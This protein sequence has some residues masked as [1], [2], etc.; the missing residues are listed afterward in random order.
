MPRTTRIALLALVALIAGAAVYVTTGRS[1]TSKPSAASVTSGSVSTTADPPSST[2]STT[3]AP[4]PVWRIVWGSTMA[5]GYGEIDNATVRQLATVKTAGSEIR[6]RVSNYF[7][8]APLQIGAATVAPSAGGSAIDA[9]AVHQVT[10]NGSPTTVIPVGGLA[11][12]DPIPMPVTG[13]ETLAISLWVS[14]ADL[15]TLHPC[16][17]TTPEGW[18]TANGRGNTTAA[19]NMVGFGTPSPWRRFVDAVDALQTTGRGSIVVIGDSITDGF[20]SSA[21]WTD[22]L[23]ERV[24][25]LPPD[26][27][28]AIINEA[29]TA[30]ALTAPPGVHTD[31]LTGGGP[32]GVERL[33][34]DVLSQAGVSEVVMLLGTND[35][36]FGAT[37]AEVIAGYQQAISQAHAAGL[38]IVA[39]TLLPRATDTDEYWS[40][41][42]QAEL[43]AVDNWIRTSGAFNAVIDTARVAADVYNG[44]CNPTAMFPPFDSG[45]HLHP[46]AAGQTAIANFIQPAVLGLPPLPTVPP[47][48]PATPTPGCS[49]A[50]TNQS[51]P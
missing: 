6:F 35:L 23:Q 15:V 8:N 28:V 11:Y 12:T 50:P 41:A 43:V 22:I 5:W 48:V 4:P 38:P 42:D 9:S 21:R 17:G 33:Q 44:Q 37:A 10:F 16:C 2:T 32:P 3:A 40:P 29:I 45:D 25:H 19:A 20:N 7:G 36:W 31:A 14:G 18:F 26:Q 51:T 24:D 49:F 30:N 13:G 39:M 47:L 34:R 27:R 46:D 1:S